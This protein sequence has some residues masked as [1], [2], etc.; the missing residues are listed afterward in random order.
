M[1]QLNNSMIII[2]Y[3]T[4]FTL[5]F[6]GDLCLLCLYMLDAPVMSNRCLAIMF[7]P[8]KSKENIPV[9]LGI[10]FPVITSKVSNLVLGCS[11]PLRGASGKFVHRLNSF[12]CRGA[13]K[14]KQCMLQILVLTHRGVRHHNFELRK[15]KNFYWTPRFSLNLSFFP[16]ADQCGDPPSCILRPTCNAERFQRLKVTEFRKDQ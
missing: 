11:K 9:V 1:S 10:H 4:E 6:I 14:I 8:M 13:Q 3:S 12:T 15:G 16:S 7:S 5:V 2:I